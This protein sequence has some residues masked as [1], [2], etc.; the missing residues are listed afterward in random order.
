MLP[1]LRGLPNRSRWTTASVPRAHSVSGEENEN[2][3]WGEM[4]DKT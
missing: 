4:E 3:V 2:R 1:A